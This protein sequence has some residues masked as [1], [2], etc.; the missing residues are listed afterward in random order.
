MGGHN[1]TDDLPKFLFLAHTS[2]EGQAVT[3]LQGKDDPTEDAEEDDGRMDERPDPLPP[4][5]PVAGHCPAYK[6]IS[7]GGD[8]DRDEVVPGG[9]NHP[10]EQRDGAELVGAGPNKPPG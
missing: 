1:E 5:K 10:E 4:T 2:Q 6:E 7:L 9:E 8:G 3:P